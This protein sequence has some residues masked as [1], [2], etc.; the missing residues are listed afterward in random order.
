MLTIPI[1]TTSVNVLKPR[2]EHPGTRP[3][4]AWLLMVTLLVVA[5]GMAYTLWWPAVVRHASWYWSEPGD[6]WGTV[7]AAH[8]VGWGGFSFIYSSQSALVTLPGFHVLLTPVVMLSSAL[9]LSETAPGLLPLPKP[10]AWLLIGPVTLACSAVALFAF[11]ALARTMRVGRGRRRLLALAEAA[12][13]WQVIAVWG[14]PEDVVALGLAVFALDQM[15]KRH[16]T[17][18]GWLL[19]AAIGMQLYAIALVPLFLGVVGFRRAPALLA[20]AAVIPGFLFVAVAVPNPHATFHA[21]FDQPNYPKVDFPTP[22]VLLAPKLGH[23]AVAAGPGRIIGLAVACAIGVLASR[24]RDFPSSIIWLAALA[25]AVRC[26]FE[27]V[28]DPYYVVPAIALALVAATKRGWIRWCLASMAGAGLTELTYFRPGMWIYWL[29]MTGVVA[30]L[31]FVTWPKRL[32][33]DTTTD[34]EPFARDARVQAGFGP[35]LVGAADHPQ[36]PEAVATV[37]ALPIQA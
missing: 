31:L 17:A 25:L 7:R 3:L 13:L 2:S 20:R 1:E 6:I 30:V 18:V 5:S 15:L 33:A 35:L 9:G 16:W 28:M 12:A 19:G 22:W 32:P 14:H 10:Q 24:R 23:G 27:S 4:T 34:S 37:P 8:W 29:E 26:L 21:L 36:P 11:D